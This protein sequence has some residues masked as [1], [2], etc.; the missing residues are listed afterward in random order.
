MVQIKNTPCMQTVRQTERK[1]KC[2][3]V[4]YVSLTD[5]FIFFVVLAAIEK[6][7]GQ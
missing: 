4:L 7:Y 2:V 3:Y 5:L 6:V 1:Q